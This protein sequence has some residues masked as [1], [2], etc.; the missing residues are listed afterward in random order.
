MQ[1]RLRK[2][3]KTKARL[4]RCEAGREPKIFTSCLGSIASSDS[5]AGPHKAPPLSHC[6]SPLASSLGYP[7]FVCVGIWLAAVPSRGPGGGRG[8]SP[9]LLHS[10]PVAAPGHGHPTELQANCHG[11][12]ASSAESCQS[13]WNRLHAQLHAWQ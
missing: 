4:G 8:G 5:Q 10:P 1:R 2:A 6:L 9:F 3:W 13:R 7:S 12:G 11:H